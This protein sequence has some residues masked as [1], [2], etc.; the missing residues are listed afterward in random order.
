M[1]HR[2]LSGSDE[3]LLIRLRLSEKNHAGKA[4]LG[5]LN[6]EIRR[7][8][9]VCLLGPSGC[10]KTTLLNLLAGLD[11]NYRGSLEPSGPGG[12]RL[13]YMFQ[14]PRLLPWRT[15]E[16]NLRL[17][18]PDAGSRI[19]RVLELVGLTRARHQFPAQL[20][21][22]MARRV[23][24]ARSF[25]IE[26]D[27][28]L[29]DEPFVSLDPPTAEGLRRHLAVLR[30]EKPDLAILL[31]THDIQEALSLADRVLLLGGAPS[32]VVRE[33]RLDGGAGLRSEESR[34][35]LEADLRSHY[36]VLGPGNATPGWA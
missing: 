19:E 1:S 21:L 14:E 32:E 17:V 16:Q 30:R 15:L 2:T 24:L 8:E 26:P 25:I 7:G 13:S 11:R 20:S 12:P 6:L 4:V 35:A 3:H 18:A 23:A 5:R 33:L 10:G 34:V 36:P 31:V 29:M 27:L 28:L 22:G 9:L